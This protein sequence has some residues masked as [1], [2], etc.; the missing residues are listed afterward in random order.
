MD[1]EGYTFVYFIKILRRFFSLKCV[2]I[3]LLLL[4]IQH[5][6]KTQ[7]TVTLFNETKGKQFYI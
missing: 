2:N 6:F 5:Y 1:F 3:M 4:T 7:V